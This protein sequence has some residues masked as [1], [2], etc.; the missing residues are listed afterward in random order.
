MELI[1]ITEIGQYVLRT[2][3][4]F[5]ENNYSTKH[6]HV[7]LENDESMIV[8]FTAECLPHALTF[9]YDLDLK[10]HSLYGIES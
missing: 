3:E 4:E 6:Y 7:T 1:A 2:V 8:M 9:M 5:D 10:L